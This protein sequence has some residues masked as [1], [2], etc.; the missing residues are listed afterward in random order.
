MFSSSTG[1]IFDSLDVGNI[2]ITRGIIRKK[3]VKGNALHYILHYG[4]RSSHQEMHADYTCITKKDREINDCV[5]ISCLRQLSKYTRVTKEG[6]LMSVVCLVWVF[7]ERK[8]NC[9][10][11]KERERL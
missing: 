3:I 4:N 8:K 10:L 2:C 5:I 7:V 9:V 6:I 1:I 11:G